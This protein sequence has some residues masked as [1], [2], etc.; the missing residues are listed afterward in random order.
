MQAEQRVRAHDQEKDLED[1]VERHEQQ[2]LLR[3]GLE[4]LPARYRLILILCDFQEMTHQEMASKLAL[5]IG[6]IKTHLFRARHLL[7][8]CVLA[9]APENQA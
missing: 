6:T 1:I 2:A 4:Q 9:F 3:L 7:K 5:P 8:Q